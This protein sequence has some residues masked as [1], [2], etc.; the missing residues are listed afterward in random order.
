MIG[1]R[2][3][4]SVCFSRGLHPNRLRNQAFNPPDMRRVGAMR[5]NP[6]RSLNDNLL[7]VMV[8][9]FGK[10]ARTFICRIRVPPNRQM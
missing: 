8:D 6:I 3:L 5:Q 9:K 2:I 4:N 1:A 7:A 10:F